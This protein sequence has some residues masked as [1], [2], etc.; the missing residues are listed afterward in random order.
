VKGIALRNT[1]DARMI[2]SSAGVF[3]IAGV[4]S[5]LC[6]QLHWPVRPIVRASIPEVQHVMC[7][8]CRN[9]AVWT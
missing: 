8:T 3:H 7:R 6:N 4:E 5:S 1:A 2:V 9:L